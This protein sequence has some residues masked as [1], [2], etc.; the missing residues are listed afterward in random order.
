MAEKNITYLLGAGASANCL[1]VIDELPVRMREFR[2]L[3][4]NRIIDNGKS[5]VFAP[6]QN[7]YLFDEQTIVS[8]NKLIAHIN[9]FLREVVVHNTVDTLA[10]KYYLTGRFDELIVL[11]KILITYFVFEQTYMT[12]FIREYHR[13]KKDNVKKELPDKRYDSLIATIINKRVKNLSLPDNFN[14]ITWNYDMQFELAYREYLTLGTLTEMQ[15]KIQ[16]FPNEIFLKKDIEFIDDKFSLLRLNGI[17]GLNALTNNTFNQFRPFKEDMKKDLLQKLVE[18]FFSISDED[19]KAFT[20]SW[21][22]FEEFKHI[23]EKM[24][25]VLKAAEKIMAKSDILIVIGYSFPLFNRSVDKQLF[26]NCDR[27]KKVYIQD[28][29]AEKIKS[30]MLSSFPVLTEREVSYEVLPGSNVADYRTLKKAELIIATDIVTGVD[31]FFIPPEA[32][33]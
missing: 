9:R 29:N 16:A 20:Y 25:I 28:H 15:S 11:K 33:I 7:S 18:Y 14:I 30:L 2:D 32:D 13:E 21:E 24:S 26:K 22:S 10:K 3:L 1:P 5:S 23:H 12:D 17:A 6:T 8:S 31:Q 19:L 27:L 4:E